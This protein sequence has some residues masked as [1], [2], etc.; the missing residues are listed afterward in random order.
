MAIDNLKLGKSPGKDG[1][2][3]DFY[4]TFKPLLAP[5]LLKLYNK[6]QATK[7]TPNTFALSILALIYKNKGSQENLDN[8]RPI[9]LL[10]T[11]YKILAKILANRLKQVIPSI[12]STSQVYSI[13]GRD[14]SDTALSLKYILAEMSKTTGI[15]LGIDFNKAFDRI[16]HS[17][18]WAILRK[19]GFGPNFIN[20]IQLLY[21]NAQ[22]QVKVN[23]HLTSTFT[24]NRSVRQGCPL[25]SFIFSLTTEPLITLIT[26][27]P[28]IQGIISPSGRENKI[29]V[30]ADDTNFTVRD[31]QCRRSLQLLGNI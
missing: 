26:E 29:L 15:Y 28:N 3:A 14:I 31:E 18:I 7:R 30:Y 10:N 9:S 13:P 4:K 17:F 24:I 19:F 20:W 6:M 5:I 12:V 1:L 27:S 25:S 11:D 16:N 23:G 21:T 22:S 8:Y 2:S